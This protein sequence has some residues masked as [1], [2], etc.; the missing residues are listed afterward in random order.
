MRIRITTTVAIVDGVLDEIEAFLVF[1]VHEDVGG[2]R[3]RSEE[4]AIG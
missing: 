3:G 4:G 2:G 1:G